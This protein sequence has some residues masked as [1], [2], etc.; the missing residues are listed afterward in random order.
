MGTRTDF[1]FDSMWPILFAI[2]L[3]LAAFLFVFH[4]NQDNVLFAVIWALVS[5]VSVL[6]LIAAVRKPAL[7]ID[8]GDV[9][10]YR[11]P[12]RSAQRVSGDDIH[13]VSRHKNR[14]TIERRSGGKV[15]FSLSWI[16]KAKR[17]DAV[18][19]VEQL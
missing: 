1:G 11:G 10:L 4:L 13:A 17:D 2:T 12:I 8:D 7:A 6:Q 5:V 15:Y 14:L 3:V 18:A 19:A 16:A 9:L